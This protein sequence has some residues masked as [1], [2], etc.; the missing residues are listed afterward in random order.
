MLIVSG[1]VL[2]KVGAFLWPQAAKSLFTHHACL[3]FSFV[4]GMFL[5]G[6]NIIVVLLSVKL[7]RKVVVSAFEL[8]LLFLTSTLVVRFN[9]FLKQPALSVIPCAVCV[10]HVAVA[11]GLSGTHIAPGFLEMFHHL[12]CRPLLVKHLEHFPLL[13]G[14]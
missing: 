2:D 6:V 12:F 1:M 13:E 10:R 8:L 14:D 7:F 3:C 11:F 5:L 9:A 4:V